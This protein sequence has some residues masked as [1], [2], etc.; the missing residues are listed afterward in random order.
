MSMID[1]E[2]I[3]AVATL[4][5]LGYTFSLPSGWSPPADASASSCLTESDAMLAV[6][7]RRADALSGCTEGS[8]EE[9]ELRTITDVIETYE[10]KRWP[11][12]KELG[13]KG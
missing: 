3:A 10:A 9:N 13:G 2:R 1:K 7:M 11:T 8:P 6:L 5:A 4:R 12:G